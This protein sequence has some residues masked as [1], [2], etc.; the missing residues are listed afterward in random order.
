MAQVDDWI[1]P[2]TGQRNPGF[3]K[4]IRE[5]IADLKVLLRPEET[6]IDVGCGHGYLYRA[7]GH[8]HYLGV[9][10][11]EE[12][13][14]EAR[15][16]FGDRFVRRDLFDLEGLWDVVICSRVVM[17]LNDF[18]TAI[19]KLI[20]CARRLCV[21]F[22]PLAEADSVTT[23][24]VKGNRVHFRTFSRATLAG[25]GLCRIFEHQPYATVVNEC[26]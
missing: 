1:T 15:L 16:L 10:L 24:N 18:G 22:V 17:H 26:E 23:E 9:D 13:L 19:K 7:L 6:V 5:N 20:A 3:L 11:Y 4:K 14:T 8:P 2:F 12:N 21:L 25:F